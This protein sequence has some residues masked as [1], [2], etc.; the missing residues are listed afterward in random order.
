M[1]NKKTGVPPMRRGAPL[2]SASGGAPESRNRALRILR[3]LSGASYVEFSHI[4][5]L[6]GAKPHEALKTPIK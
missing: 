1:K 3:C 5:R 6:S 4:P 2:P